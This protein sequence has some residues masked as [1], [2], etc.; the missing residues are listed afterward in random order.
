MG[1]FFNG[2][3]RKA[4]VVTLVVACILA[5]LIIRARYVS[6]QVE[7]GSGETL[8]AI[9]IQLHRIM[10]VFKESPLAWPILCLLTSLSAYLLLSKPRPPKR[11]SLTE[12]PTQT[13]PSSQP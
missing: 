12:S 13:P 2:W 1:E 9:S 10:I 11:A 7:M 3:R 4:G 8:N 6:M 5:S